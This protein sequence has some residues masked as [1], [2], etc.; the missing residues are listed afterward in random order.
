MPTIFLSLRIKSTTLFCKI[1]TNF[2][3]QKVKKINGIFYAGQ[4]FLMM[5][6]ST[7]YDEYIDR[8]Q[9][10]QKKNIW[11]CSSPVQIQTSCIVILTIYRHDFHWHYR[12]EWTAAS[13]LS[14]NRI[15]R[16]QRM[17]WNWMCPLCRD[18]ILCSISR[19]NWTRCTP[20]SQGTVMHRK[21]W[22][23]DFYCKNSNRSQI[24]IVWAWPIFLWIPGSSFQNFTPGSQ[25]GNRKWR[26]LHNARFNGFSKFSSV[27]F[28]WCYSTRYSDMIYSPQFLHSFHYFPLK[29]AHFVEKVFRPWKWKKFGKNLL[30]ALMFCWHNKVMSQNNLYFN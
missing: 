7:L 3:K 27:I 8:P 15:V 11:A 21:V 28:C 20:Q 16:V 6:V 23:T 30:I 9:S 29:C 5:P 13:F 10:E 25:F 12:W 26:C 22:N 14:K 4:A 19:R 1:L 17:R 18:D 24:W 2:S